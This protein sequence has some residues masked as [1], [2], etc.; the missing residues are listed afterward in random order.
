MKS[1]RPYTI[2]EIITGRID[3]IIIVKFIVYFV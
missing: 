3:V 2:Y 1:L